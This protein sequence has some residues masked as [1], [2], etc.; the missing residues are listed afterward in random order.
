VLLFAFVV[1]SGYRKAVAAYGR[2]PT[3]GSLRIAFFVAV[4][5]E[6]LTEA[7]FRMMTPTWFLL[8]WAM[9]DNSM[10]RNLNPRRERQK[11]SLPVKAWFGTPAMKKAVYANSS[12]IR[13]SAS[14]RSGFNE[15]DEAE[16]PQLSRR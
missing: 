14:T 10:A 3:I 11:R 6:G 5:I 8:L 1:V 15:I 7:P 12:L 2:D 4:L 9:I 13:D 16:L